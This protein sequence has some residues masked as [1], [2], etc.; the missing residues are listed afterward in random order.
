MAN[1][2]HL[3]ILKEGRTSWNTWRKH[4]PEIEPDLSEADLE[5]EVLSFFD[6]SAS[7]LR[8][9]N[10]SKAYLYNSML[11]RTDLSDS[12]LHNT[13]LHSTNLSHARVALARLS[14]ANLVNA[15]LESAD[16]RNADLSR[17]SL[18]GANL[19][20]I[21]LSGANLDGADVSET[22]LTD[23]ILIGTKFDNASLNNANLSNAALTDA[24]FDNAS[25]GS[26]LF[27]NNDLSLVRNL[28]TVRPLKPSTLGV[29]TLYRSFG[30]IPRSFLIACDVPEA[31]I[32]YAA[33]LVASNQP[34]QF[35]SCFISYSHKDEAFAK[36]LYSRLRDANLRVWFAPADMKAGQ[37]L[38][39]QIDQAIQLY[40]KLLIILSDDSM[41]S[42][43]VK[44]EI[45]NARRTEIS[46][47][48]K[49]LFPIGLISFQKIKDWQC[50]DVD[51]GMDLAVML[52]EYYIPDFS[53]WND[54]DTC[55]AEF[56]RLI[57]SLKTNHT[58]IGSTEKR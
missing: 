23:S 18:R 28:D 56:A 40:D 57:S 8:G 43:W 33:S 10:L 17:S 13:N 25:I 52:R 1:K 44:T 24:D 22:N 36:Q 50:F 20:R 35:H 51:T 27:C 9:I 29:D 42:E 30:N 45:R 58:S 14:E 49:K 5:G 39:D 34:V 7:N 53:N 48:Y 41:K 11:V 15:K 16:F 2:N 54:P 4:N 6:F 55:E 47:N 46:E 19:A 37:R 21:N 12:L 32:T 31:L 26:T 38:Y 3:R